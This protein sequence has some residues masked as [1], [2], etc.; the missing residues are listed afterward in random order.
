MSSPPFRIS[1]LLVFWVI[2][3]AAAGMGAFGVFGIPIAALVV[4]MWYL[5][6]SWMAILIGAMI[7]LCAGAGLIMPAVQGAREAARRTQ[8]INNLRQIGL[9][10]LNYHDAKGHWP[11]AYIAD[12]DGTPMH[13]WRVLI[14]EFMDDDKSL[15]NKYRF[16]EPWDGPN[17][18]KLISE[19]PYVYQCPTQ[20]NMQPGHTRYSAVIGPHT[21]WTRQPDETPR[22]DYPKPP[23]P[24][25]CETFKDVP[26]TKPT[27][28]DTEELIKML[29]DHAGQAFAGGHQL[30]T[31]WTVHQHQVPIG[32]SDGAVGSIALPKDLQ[33]LRTTRLE[34]RDRFAAAHGE[35]RWKWGRIV[36]IVCFV[37]LSLV[38]FWYR[39][40]QK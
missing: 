29:E 28:F 1:L 7:L 3:L 9:G 39:R 13:S 15:F 5:R 21:T 35:Y 19:M 14:L 6:P 33:L 37:L 30:E 25:V 11:P 38:P 26:W 16:D 24:L 34:T 4:W 20:N 2:S 18:R 22:H 12:E 40:K 17:N 10:I 32:Y 8:C 31:F 27:D 36:S 23:C